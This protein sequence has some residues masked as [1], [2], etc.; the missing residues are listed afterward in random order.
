MDNNTGEILSLAIETGRIM[1]QNG[2]EIFRVED[3]M[4]RIATYY[5]VNDND[6]FVLTNGI[7]TSA[8]E[9]NGNSFARIRYIP[10]NSPNLAKVIA[11]NQ[12]SRE[13]VMGRYTLEEF[14]KEL[15][16]IDKIGTLPKSLSIWA[17]SLS[18][19]CFT[20]LFSG[21]IRD[22]LG[23]LTAGFI[24]WLFLNYLSKP[25]LSKITSNL[26]SSLLV[27]IVC[28]FFHYFGFS[29]NLNAMIAGAIIP[30]IP[31]I[32][33]VNGIRDIGNGDYIS[34]AVRLLDSIFVFIC[35]SVGVGIVL[36]F[37]SKV[38]GGLFL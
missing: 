34:G 22:A 24:L 21:T 3:T 23:A 14:K 29:D 19:G 16:R 31:G 18:A 25:Y 20:I 32:T 17:T 13:I 10:V 4:K 1:L 37:Y 38:Q 12:L 35:I 27:T 28:L 9:E 26:L 5:G 7:F 33:F 30:L 36:T 8:L 15:K 2:A 6:F 11:V